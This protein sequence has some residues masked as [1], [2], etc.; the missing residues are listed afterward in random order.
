MTT[1]YTSLLGLALPVTG[2]LSGTWG[3]TVNDFITQYT[4]AAVAGTQ[5]ISGSQTA[6]TLSV[7]NGAPLSQVGSGST[8]SAQYAVINC[9]GSPASL[10]TITVPASSRQYMVI[11]ATSTNQSVKVVGVGPTTGVT[12]AAGEEAIIAW[13]GSD[14]IKIASSTGVSGPA[15]STDNAIARFDGTTGQIIQ[16]SSVIIA[17][18]GSMVIS[19]NSSTDALRITQTGTGNALSVEDST[20]PDSTPFVIDTD[21]NVIKGAT[22]RTVTSANNLTV[23][24]QFLGAGG[25]TGNLGI[26]RWD[27]TA[28]SSPALIMGRA[29]G[30]T[31][32]TNTIVNNGDRLG[33]ISFGG[34]DGTNFIEGANILGAVDGT[35]GTNDMPGRLVF[36]TTAD[37]ASAS[38]ERMRIDNQGRVGIGASPFFSTQFLLSGAAGFDAAQTSVYAARANTTMP[39]TG[40]TSQD[41]FATTLVGNAASHTAANVQHFHARSYTVGAS[42]TVTNQFGFYANSALTGATNNY[43]FYSNIA[44][45]TGRWNFYA[46]GTAENFFGGVTTFRAANAVRVEAASTQDAIVVAGRAGGTSSYAVTLTP[47]TLTASRTVTFPDANI[48]FSTGLPAANG[49]TGLTSVGTSGNILTS[50][51]TTWTSTNALAS[52]VTATTQAEK[53]ADTTIA[54]TAFVDRLRSLTTSTTGT[55]GTLVVGDRGSLVSATGG[56]TVPANV[57][58]AR[59]V[60]TIFNNSAANITITQGASLTLY[61][62]GTATTGNRTLAQR[63]LATIVFISATVAVI[64][65]GG[66]S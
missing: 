10:L 4:D 30:T 34:A 48:N 1:A 47:T 62:A 59:D 20:N 56:I 38:T 15:S 32:G 54:T 9:T 25:A 31:L 12:M 16:N 44:S 37:G 65:G 41:G 42:Q 11:N 50:D 45:G 3:D 27:T 46:N 43:G 13:N 57:F 58:S 19:T 17:D 8:G 24:N 21:G 52:T 6:V 53:T 61:L 26:F 51:G 63:G 2:E 49:G 7:T 35:P 14:F 33:I 64:S 66:V 40:T 5:T 18:D 28:A 39:S 29:Q 55:S 36:S 23:T 60:V 22:S